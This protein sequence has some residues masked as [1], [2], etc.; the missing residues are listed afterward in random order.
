MLTFS[1][2]CSFNLFGHQRV[3]DGEKKALNLFN[4]MWSK[5]SK[6]CHM[7]CHFCP[8]H[9]NN[10]LLKKTMIMM[11]TTGRIQRYQSFLFCFRLSDPLVVETFPIWQPWTFLH[12]SEFPI[13]LY[14]VSAG[15]A[16][17]VWLTSCCSSGRL[18]CH[19]CQ[20]E[21]LSA[22]LQLS[23]IHHWLSASAMSL[24]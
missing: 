15:T 24:P 19:V 14:S 23:F 11:K 6:S 2:H 9:R 21:R 3:R 22:S 12:K 16:S 5:L 13:S 8:S 10:H 17:S 4:I 1:T 20:W 18:R 7:R